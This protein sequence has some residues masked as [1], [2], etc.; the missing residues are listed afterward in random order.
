MSRPSKNNVDYFPFICKIGDAMQYMED[1]YGNDGFATWVKILRAIA[2]KNHH[3]LMLDNEKAIK[4]LASNCKISKEL[5]FQI[6]NDLCDFNEFDKELWESKRVLWSQKFI[7]NIQEAYKRRT[8][9]CITKQELLIKLGMSEE[10]V[11]PEKPKKTKPTDVKLKPVKEEKDTTPK[12]YSTLTPSRFYSIDMLGDVYI[13]DERLLSAVSKTTG[14]SVKDI[15]A[16]VSEFKE[17]LF[18]QGKSQETASEFAKY[19]KNW[20]KY[21]E[22]PAET[23][24]SKEP[25]LDWT[26]LNTNELTSLGYKEQMELIKKRMSA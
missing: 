12:S 10:I 18:G 13:K 26:L 4:V 7:D 25:K 16:F 21:Q 24:A 14:K 20:L 17:N 5:L 3:H 9:D 6:I 11:A 23:N 8:N 22:K 2:V 15:K 19:F 1:N